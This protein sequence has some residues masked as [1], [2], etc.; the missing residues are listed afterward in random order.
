[1]AA[2]PLTA[3]ADA[4]EAL[5]A[6]LRTLEQAAPAPAPGTRAAVEGLRVTE[7][8]T[9]L[10]CPE[11]TVRDLIASGRLHAVRAGKR[12]LIAS[13]EVERFLTG[14]PSD[15]PERLGRLTSIR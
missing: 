9:R 6:A 8:A 10:H 1:M 12:W 2:T 5:A 4:L 15:L 13:T 3:V 7:A 14:T 11:Q